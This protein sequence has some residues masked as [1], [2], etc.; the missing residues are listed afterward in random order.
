M[1]FSSILLCGFALAAACGVSSPDDRSAAP[2]SSIDESALSSTEPVVDPDAF[3]LLAAD[4]GACHGTIRADTSIYVCPI[5][6][7]PARSCGVMQCGVPCAGGHATAGLQPQEVTRLCL[8]PNGTSFRE[9]VPTL[10]KKICGA[11][12]PPI[13]DELVSAR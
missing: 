3:A 2:Q 7:E 5:D 6:F 11:C 1:K 10:R 12:D 4:F 9:W 8:G 13:P